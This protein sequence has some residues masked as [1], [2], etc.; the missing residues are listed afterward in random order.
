MA[1]SALIRPL[2]YGIAQS[3]C[4]LVHR[5]KEGSAHARMKL[6]LLTSE[7]LLDNIKILKALHRHDKA[8]KL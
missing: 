3:R 1:V 4:S 6:S 8:P 5:W 7:N 2:G